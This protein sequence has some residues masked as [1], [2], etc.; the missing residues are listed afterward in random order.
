MSLF[1]VNMRLSLIIKLA[2]LTSLILVAFM[3]ISAYVNL[4]DLRR[5]FLQ[6]AASDTGK[7]SET[8]INT[9]NYQMLINDLPRVFSM[10]REVGTLE[11]IEHISLIST[12]GRV[13]FSTDESRIRG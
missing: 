2:L 4:K 1:E 3:T 5:L 9:T 7:L 6:E 13:I 10:I 11:G 12:E 8:I